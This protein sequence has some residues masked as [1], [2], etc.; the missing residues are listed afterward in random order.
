MRAVGSTCARFSAVAEGGLWA[1]SGRSGTGGPPAG[2]ATTP[3]TP[4][5]RSRARLA[6]DDR[7]LLER[8]LAVR[9]LGA[10][11]RVVA[12]E[13]GVAV[14]LARS[15]GSPRRHRRG[16]GR[17]ASR[18]PA[19]RAISSTRAAV[20]DHLLRAWTCRC[21]SG[22]GGGSAGPRSAGGSRA[23]PRRAASGRSGA[24]CCRA[25]S[26]RRPPPAACRSTTSRQRVELHPQ[27]VLAQLL[28][29]LDER[30]RDV[31]VLDQAVVARDARSLR[32]AVRGR[33][34]GVGHGDHH[35]GLDRRLARTGS[36]PSCAATPACGCPR[37]SS[38]GG[39]SRCARRRR[40]PCG[41]D[42]TTWRVSMPRSLSEISSPGRD[43][44]QQLGADD[45]EGAALG[46]DAVAVAEPA[47]A[48]SGR[49]PA[50]GRGRPTTASLV[51]TTVEK[52]PSSRGITS[53]TA[54]SIALG[55]MGGEQRGDDLRV[56]GAAELHA[57]LAELV[58]QLDRVDQVAVVRQRDL[59]G[60]PSATPAGRSPRR[61]EP[62]VE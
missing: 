20:G 7:Q 2:R 32:V 56:R 48:Q 35:V 11:E 34:A 18:S 61:D 29:R 13:A 50:P 16:T 3:R 25:R 52:A 41:R 47:R 60:G 42:S 9:V 59:R 55:R 49:R 17:R 21:R 1:T 62:V 12:R 46:G 27:A 40:R 31:A 24:W 28:P 4:S 36:R 8:E 26:S 10:L 54:S 14:R 23:R 37:A 33:V 30:A 43:L 22:R 51:M 38:P 58:V 44:A 57:R 53:A 19:P 6:A 45:V 15:S 5:P 39:R